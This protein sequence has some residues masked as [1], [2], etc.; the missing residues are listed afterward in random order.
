MNLKSLEDSL[1]ELTS[2][3][4]AL[5]GRLEAAKFEI[6][7]LRMHE[8]DPPNRGTGRTTAR[9]LHSIADALLRP[10]EEVAVV[11]DYVDGKD[12]ESGYAFEACLIDICKLLR[13]TIRTRREGAVVFLC[14]PF[15]MVRKEAGE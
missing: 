14:S 6:A 9:I 15:S 5:T 7:R 3:L 2:R 4:D 10:D 8:G 11:S 1:N 13:L 12:S